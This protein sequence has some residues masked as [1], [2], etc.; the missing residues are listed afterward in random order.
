MI[1]AYYVYWGRLQVNDK[2]GKKWESIC[3]AYYITSGLYCW[4]YVCGSV[5]QNFGK[6]LCYMHELPVRIYCCRGY[7][8]HE[9]ACDELGTEALHIVQWYG[10][11]KYC[12]VTFSLC[13]FLD[14]I[15]QGKNRRK[16]FFGLATDFLTFVCRGVGVLIVFQLQ[17]ST[18]A[19]YK[20]QQQRCRFHTTFPMT[21]GIL[22]WGT[23]GH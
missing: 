1:Y 23:Y 21:Y 18:A 2:P 10:L 19:N 13:E 5:V 20:D 16:D 6:V 17:R 22:S 4:Y 9:E 11:S 14:K 8:A 12:T 15:T 7:F 3:I